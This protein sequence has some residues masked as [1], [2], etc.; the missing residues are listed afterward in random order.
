VGIIARVLVLLLFY[1]SLPLSWLWTLLFS[2]LSELYTL[3]D[4]LL[5]PLAVKGGTAP[6]PHA[7]IASYGATP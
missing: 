7:V 2:W 1:N 3:H 5:L 6:P 4:R